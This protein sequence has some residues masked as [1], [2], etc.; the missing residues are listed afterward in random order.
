MEQF[1]GLTPS[2]LD[3]LREV[4]IPGLFKR[5]MPSDAREKL[6]ELGYVE[7]RPDGL[8]ATAN[9]LS[10][11]SLGAAEAKKNMAPWRVK[12]HATQSINAIGA[13]EGCSFK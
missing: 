9:P 8:V 3:A 7:Q 11:Y 4:A 10:R 1:I 6:I 12:R 5:K 13:R 2:L